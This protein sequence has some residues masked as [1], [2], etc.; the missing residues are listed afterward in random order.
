MQIT[1]GSIGPLHVHR[2]ELKPSRCQAIQV[3]NATLC[4]QH[5][6]VSI[7]TI[8]C[9]LSS[10]QLVQLATS[11]SMQFYHN[12]SSK[13]DNVSSASRAQYKLFHVHGMPCLF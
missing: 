10:Q 11:V 1:P 5:C 3:I 7:P 13:Y 2:K 4:K 6:K 8:S 12:C 9:A